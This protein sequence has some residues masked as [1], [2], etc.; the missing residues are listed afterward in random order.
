[1]FIYSF[2]A[3]DASINVHIFFQSQAI[4]ANRLNYCETQLAEL[5]EAALKF[6]NDFEL[7]HDIFNGYLLGIGYLYGALYAALGKYT[8]KDYGEG[9]STDELKSDMKE[10][11]DAYFVL[12]ADTSDILHRIQQNLFN[13]TEMISCFENENNLNCQ[14]R[15]STISCETELNKLRC[16][17]ADFFEGTVKGFKRDVLNLDVVLDTCTFLTKL[18]RNFYSKNKIYCGPSCSTSEKDLRRNIRNYIASFSSH[19]VMNAHNKLENTA[20]S[21]NTLIDAINVWQS[22]LS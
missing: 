6:F 20:S 5:R 8:S 1:M 17:L 12:E 2:L 10:F 11:L 22:Q 9:F 3:T 13:L 21:C 16:D 14:R 15:S 4:H 19:Q 18:T 7:A